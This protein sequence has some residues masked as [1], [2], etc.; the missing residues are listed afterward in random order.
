MLSPCPLWRYC[1]KKPTAWEIEQMRPTLSAL[2]TVGLGLALAGCDTTLPVPHLGAAPAEVTRLVSDAPPG[3][4]SGSCWGK[5]ITPG[6]YETVTEQVM[7]QPAEILADGRVISPAIYKTETRQAVVQ[8][9]RETWFETLC[10]EQMTP[11]LVA[12]LQR[13]L[14]ARGVYR[15]GISGNM[16]RATLAAIRAYQKPQGLDSNILSL[17]AARRLGLVAVELD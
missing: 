8:E 5:R 10:R 7:L 16:D 3:A 2:L 12:T 15:G 17:A 11:E 9:R 1:V 14:Q 4:R 13:A 6:I